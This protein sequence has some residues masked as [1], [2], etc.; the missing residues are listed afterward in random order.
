MFETAERR[1]PGFAAARGVVLAPSELFLALAAPNQDPEFLA[2]AAVNLLLEGVDR[3]PAPAQVGER[4]R[5]EGRELVFD[6]STDTMPFRRFMT[7]WKKA[8][9]HCRVNLD[10][11]AVSPCTTTVV[12]VPSEGSMGR[13]APPGDSDPHRRK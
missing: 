6:Y 9:L 12:E 4:A 10:T 13:P 7:S 3:H 11:A 5:I 1:G 8:I 2:N